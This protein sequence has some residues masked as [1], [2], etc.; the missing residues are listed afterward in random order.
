[1]EQPVRDL[2]EGEAFLDLV[3]SNPQDSLQHLLQRASM[4]ANDHNITKFKILVGIKR[5]KTYSTIA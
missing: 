2:T 1:M 4:I 5:E 3:P